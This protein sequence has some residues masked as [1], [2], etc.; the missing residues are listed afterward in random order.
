MVLSCAGRLTLLDAPPTRYGFR[1]CACLVNYH[2]ILTRLDDGRPLPLVFA[3]S[4]LNVGDAFF[5]ECHRID[6]YISTS[7]ISLQRKVHTTGRKSLPA[8]G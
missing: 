1:G 3:V 4:A 6:V 2:A 8:P 7:L 5:L